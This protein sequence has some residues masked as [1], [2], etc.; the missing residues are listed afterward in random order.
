M[1][2]PERGKEISYRSLSVTCRAWLCKALGPEPCFAS[3]FMNLISLIQQFCSSI[4][5][6]LSCC[7]FFM[8]PAS[9]LSSQA[10]SPPL[11][12]ISRSFRL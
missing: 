1:D 12:P 10:I 4:N 6:S 5:T 11:H 8:V 2:Q 9:S 7:T 3:S